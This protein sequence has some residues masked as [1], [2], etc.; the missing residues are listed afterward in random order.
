MSHYDLVT[1]ETADDIAKPILKNAKANFG[2]VPNFFA[3]IGIDG[4]S[5][6]TFL[7]SQESLNKAT[8]LSPKERELI[9]LSV[10]NHNGCHYCVSGHTFS[11]KKVGLTSEECVNAQKGIANDARGQIIIDIAISI[12][13]NNGHIDEKIRTEA[14]KIG[15]T[16]AEILQITAYTALNSWSNWVNNI[17][18]P[19]IDFPK[20]DLI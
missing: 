2:M 5:L 13:K 12:L 19:T 3:A 14:S 6:S 18:D 4:T 17:V 9:A 1:I 11:A 8:T 7:S 16:P 20:V 15:L 10:A